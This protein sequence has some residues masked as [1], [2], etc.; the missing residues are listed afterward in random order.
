MNRLEKDLLFYSNYCLHSSNLINQVSKTPLHQK[1]FYICIDDKKIKI[2]NFITRVPSIFLVQQKKV[3]VEDEIDNFISKRLRELQPPPTQFLQQSGD[4]SNLIPQQ[5]RDMPEQQQRDMPEQ[6]QPPQQQKQEE[7][8][9]EIAA[10]HF[11]EMGN[12]LSDQYSFIEENENSSLNHNFSFIDGAN[13]GDT[14]I[15]TPK[16][17]NSKDEKKPKMSSDFDKLMEARNNEAFS[18]GIQRV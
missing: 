10:Y 7:G 5:Q 1:M 3:L 11:N 14:R 6:Q 4:M 15:N 17:F 13:V 16:E 12:N 9:L 18:K 8:E 2:P